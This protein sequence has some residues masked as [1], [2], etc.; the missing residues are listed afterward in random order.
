MRVSKD[1]NLSFRPEGR[2]KAPGGLN[3]AVR[4]RTSA[5][6]PELFLG[7]GKDM[8]H[9]KPDAVNGHS[10]RKRKAH[11]WSIHISPDRYG[12]GDQFQPIQDGYRTNIT[13]VE[14]QIDA[15]EHVF[16]LVVEIAVCV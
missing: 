1:D 10:K 3:S 15:R 8:D 7:R 2:P 12:G 6:L 9:L 4:Q 5:P 11:R 13:G 16:Q 14:D